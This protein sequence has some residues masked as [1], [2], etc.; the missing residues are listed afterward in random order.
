ME[1]GAVVSFE[2]F[3]NFSLNLFQ[4]VPFFTHSFLKDL[5]YFYKNENK[6]LFKNIKECLKKFYFIGITENYDIDALFLYYKM[7]IKKFFNNKNIS[8]VYYNP[9]EDERKEIGKILNEKN[10]IDYLLYN[11]A[12]KFNS[13]FKIEHP[14]FKMIVRCMRVKFFFYY[15][16]LFFYKIQFLQY[17]YE[18]SAKFNKKSKIYSKC[19]S[20]IKKELWKK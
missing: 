8:R 5:G 11:E 19:I 12:L 1:N 6:V 18:L 17:F 20:L 4:T 15:P 3:L 2:R 16:I 7:S 10:I 14:E 9:S 13:Q